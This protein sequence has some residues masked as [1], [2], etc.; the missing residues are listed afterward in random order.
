[1]ALKDHE[2][3]RSFLGLKEAFAHW[4]V[5]QNSEEVDVGQHGT[6]FTRHHR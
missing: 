5:I 2:E 6:M 3:P 1:M 4:N